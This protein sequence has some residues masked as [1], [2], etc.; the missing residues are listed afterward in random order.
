[1]SLNRPHSYSHPQDYFAISLLAMAGMYF[2]NAALTYLN[3][4]TRIVF[5]S[6]RVL[7]VMAFRALVVGARY[8]AAQYA[9]GTGRTCLHGV[10]ALCG[11]APR[12][13][14]QALCCTADGACVG[15][16]CCSAGG[17]CLLL[18]WCS[19]AW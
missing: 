16:L 11:T 5:K 15:L 1:M 3:Y 2:T 9:A 14:P 7:P 17:P 13:M 18:L 12:S 6:C 10:D 4:T 8:S 19:G